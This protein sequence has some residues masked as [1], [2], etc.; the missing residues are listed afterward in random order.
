MTFFNLQVLSNLGKMKKTVTSIDD[1]VKEGLQSNSGGGGWR[2][3]RGNRKKGRLKKKNPIKTIFKL[4]GTQT[5]FLSS[6]PCRINMSMFE[7]SWLKDVYRCYSCR[8]RGCTPRP[9]GSPARTRL[10][11]SNCINQTILT[12]SFYMCAPISELLC[13]I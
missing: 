9:G 4:W 13:I 3:K 5:W 2:K 7:L 8:L 1:W 12:I 11:P 6:P 10:D